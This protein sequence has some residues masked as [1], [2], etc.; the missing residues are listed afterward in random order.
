MAAF[1]TT[2]NEKPAEATIPGG[3]ILVFSTT[4]PPT[5]EQ[6]NVNYHTRCAP[7]RAR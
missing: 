3:L 1:T 7:S 5:K 4:H 2:A 6:M